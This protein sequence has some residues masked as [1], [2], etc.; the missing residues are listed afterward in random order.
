MS[1]PSKQAKKT[2]KSPS[3]PP[4]APKVAKEKEEVK[5][6]LDSFLHHVARIATNGVDIIGFNS[7]VRIVQESVV[8]PGGKKPS[9]QEAA[10]L[11]KTKIQMAAHQVKQS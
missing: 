9:P 8:L 6:D 10:D 4:S 5:V 11:I 1:E 3:P 2:A 7:A